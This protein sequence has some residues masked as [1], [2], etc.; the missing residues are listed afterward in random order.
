M[1]D[2]G[3]GFKGSIPGFGTPGA[4]FIPKVTETDEA[5]ELS[6]ENNRGLPNPAPVVIPR[7]RDGLT[8]YQIAVANGFEGTE[9]EW[10]AALKGKDGDPGMTAYEYAKE[11][12]Y[13]GTEEEFA[14]KLAEEYPAPDWNAA[15]GEAGHILNRPFYKES[16]ETVIL[17][18]TELEYSADSGGYMAEIAEVPAVGATVTTVWNGVT[19]SS[20]VYAGSAIA[21]GVVIFG[22][23][24]GLYGDE[25]ASAFGVPAV[26]TGE[27]FA[28]MCAAEDGAAFM[29]VAPLDGSTDNLTLS[30]S[31]AAEVI[32]KIPEEYL[33]GLN[34]DAFEI[35]PKTYGRGEVLLSPTAIDLNN[36]VF[37]ADAFPDGVVP[38]LEV[39]KVY[40]VSVNDRE[41]LV[42][43]RE[44]S[45]GAILMG[46]ESTGSLTTEMPFIVCNYVGSAWVLSAIDPTE[47]NSI[48]N[49]TVGVYTATPNTALERVS[50]DMLPFGVLTDVKLR[51][52][53]DA[54]GLPRTDAGGNV[55][56]LDNKY[57][58]T[59]WNAVQEPYQVE[60]VAETAFTA[61][62]ARKLTTL[63]GVVSNRPDSWPGGAIITFDGVEYTF[64]G[65]STSYGNEYAKSTSGTDT[66][67]PFY[68]QT[69]T[70]SAMRLYCLEA[71]DHTIAV[72]LYPTA[73]VPMP[74]EYLPE[75]VD[76][77]IVRSSTADST[78]KFKITVDDS[79]TITATEV[80]E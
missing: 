39:G 52:M 27:P 47:D 58:D 59:E 10:L 46:A 20:T 56:K 78:K 30:V 70:A 65:H 40:L 8:A 79:G 38:T 26:D 66:G 36:T 44:D 14:E 1:A 77:V 21:E 73:P 42:T 68:I 16:G 32:H 34:G 41:Y 72:T 67:E 2:C 37:E 64:D 9:A 22:N 13:T 29:M 35:W 75:S 54:Q 50:E 80:A 33:P 49:C 53:Q 25:G 19:Y 43:T 24:Y 17:A 69:I 12:G 5:V 76:G 51:Q 55:Y 74:E 15:E 71:G 6:W 23:V 18:E 45:S 63:S 7:G 62:A 28:I 48:R 60:V 61:T 4:T 31:V 57:L 3:C 11:G